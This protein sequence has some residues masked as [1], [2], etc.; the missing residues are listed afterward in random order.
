MVD[1][2]QESS[3]CSC[4]AKPTFNIILDNQ[5]SLSIFIPDHFRFY[6]NAGSVYGSGLIIY[7]KFET[8][9][10][11]WMYLARYDIEMLGILDK[12]QFRNSFFHVK[13]KY[14]TSGETA[15]KV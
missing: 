13:Y 11:R 5:A 10:N 6:E 15:E 14:F 7:L 4:A 1:K 3:S 9:P 12:L 8:E 2:T